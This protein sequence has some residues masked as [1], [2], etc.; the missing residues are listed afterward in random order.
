MRLLAFGTSLDGG[1]NE[2]EAALA[3]L[4]T[5]DQQRRRRFVELGLVVVAGE[6]KRAFGL[7]SDA[8]FFGQLVGQAIVALKVADVA[9]EQEA[10]EVFFDG[11][12]GFDQLDFD[13][14]GLLG[15]FVDADAV[16]FHGGEMIAGRTR[17]AKLPSP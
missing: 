12:F 15:G 14:F 7:V 16:E 3:G 11:V 1:V 17:L 8:K 9:G 2:A 5:D 10:Q 13:A 4:D 6:D